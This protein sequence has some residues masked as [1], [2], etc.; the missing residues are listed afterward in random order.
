MQFG[1]AP[2]KWNQISTFV[3]KACT[4]SVAKTK[5]NQLKNKYDFN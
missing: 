4:T 1:F 3:A 2:A 5:K